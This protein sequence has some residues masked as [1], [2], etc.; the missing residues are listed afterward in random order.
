M[1]Q[2]PP[3]SSV[4][5]CQLLGTFWTNQISGKARIE[6]LIGCHRCGKLIKSPGSGGD[7]L[8][9]GTPHS[10]HH[11]NSPN[12][13]PMK[14]HPH[15]LYI[16]IYIDYSSHLDL[17]IFLQPRSFRSFAFTSQPASSFELSSIHN[18]I[19]P[20]LLSTRWVSKTQETRCCS[21]VF[22][23]CFSHQGNLGSPGRV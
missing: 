11:E 22:P 20:K 19:A 2:S 14:C 1:I 12:T 18:M 9:W 5:S 23:D 13:C 7:T 8:I 10:N 15:K 3:R 4:S 21:I 17:A 16:Y 6:D